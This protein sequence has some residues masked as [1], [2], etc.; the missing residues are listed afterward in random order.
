MARFSVVM[1]A[2]IR[3]PIVNQESIRSDK[4]LANRPKEADPL[5]KMRTTK[6]ARIARNQTIGGRNGGGTANQAWERVYKPSWTAA[7]VQPSETPVSKTAAGLTQAW[8]Q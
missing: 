8:H 4:G 1:H 2:A 3:R 7:V 5:V 6:R